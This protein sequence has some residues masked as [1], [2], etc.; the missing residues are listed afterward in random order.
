MRLSKLKKI[1]SM[2]QGSK[3][4]RTL[5]L[6]GVG[7]VGMFLTCCDDDNQVTISNGIAIREFDIPKTNLAGFS[8][9]LTTSGK[10]GLIYINTNGTKTAN[11]FYQSTA[12]S[13]LT[14]TAKSIAT[15]GTTKTTSGNFGVFFSEK[16]NVINYK[17]YNSSAQVIRESSNVLNGDVTGI[18]LAT[19]TNN[20]VVAAVSYKT[21]MG[22]NDVCFLVFDENCNQVG[23]LTITTFGSQLMGETSIGLPQVA[24]D[25]N[26]KIEIAIAS[27]EKSLFEVYTYNLT[28]WSAAG[29]NSKVNEF[30]LTCKSTNQGLFAITS[31]TKVT[32]G[33]KL[34][35]TTTLNLYYFNDSNSFVLSQAASGNPISADVVQYWKKSSN[36][37][38]SNIPD[39]DNSFFITS[40]NIVDNSLNANGYTFSDPA[41]LVVVNPLPTI[42]NNSGFIL[43]SLGNLNLVS[44]SLN[45]GYFA[46]MAAGSVYGGVGNFATGQ[47]SFVRK[48]SD[49]VPFDAQVS[50]GPNGEYVF[51]WT[52]ASGRVET[53]PSSGSSPT[54]RG[55]LQK[56]S[57]VKVQKG[58]AR[59]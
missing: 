48:L 24:I 26:N 25:K 50:I 33:S 13:S 57:P 32:T 28:G 51:F 1:G 49:Q 55:A 59:P 2:I 20:Y 46:A 41:A 23:S 44:V 18:N 54:I 52:D 4:R 19:N 29:G 11:K 53:Y 37:S 27:N 30:V 22:E 8:C 42:T 3:V 47:V 17:F 15:P 34:N 12:N 31:G 7:M 16:N 10:S 21:S 6:V 43:D 35:D 39:T 58:L 45:N 36:G 5:C 9:F 56:F 38:A 40:M 14:I